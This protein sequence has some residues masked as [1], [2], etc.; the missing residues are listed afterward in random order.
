MSSLGMVMNGELRQLIIHT[1]DIEEILDLLNMD[2][3][4]VVDK[5]DDEISDME[6]TFW[7]AVS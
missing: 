3:T 6:D 7:D 5:F 4:D 1:L 2:I